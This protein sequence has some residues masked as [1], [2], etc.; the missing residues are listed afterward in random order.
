MEAEDEMI[1]AEGE[2]LTIKPS[3][4]IAINFADE[5]LLTLVPGIKAKLAKALVAVR[6]NSG[7][8]TP[9]VL[10]SICRRKFSSLILSMIDFTKNKKVVESSEEEDSECEGSPSDSDGEEDQTKPS[11]KV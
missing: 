5:Q 1:G 3:G 7:N 10:E 2:I 8:I 11:G 4:M 9:E 6:E